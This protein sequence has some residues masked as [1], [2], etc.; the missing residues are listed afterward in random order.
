MSANS[1]NTASSL[2]ADFSAAARDK[3]LKSVERV[4]TFAGYGCLGLVV[5]TALETGT[6]YNESS[7]LLS[8]GALFLFGLSTGAGILRE[9]GDATHSRF[10][11]VLK[12]TNSAIAVAAAMATPRMLDAVFQAYSTKQVSSSLLVDFMATASSPQVAFTAGLAVAGAYLYHKAYQLN[13]ALALTKPAQ[14][15]VASVP[16][17]PQPAR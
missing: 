6:L 17:A 2:T 4:S 5:K 11:K 12:Y 10:L 14:Q 8:A 15:P 1:P 13:E 16:R 3:F 9:G 7:A